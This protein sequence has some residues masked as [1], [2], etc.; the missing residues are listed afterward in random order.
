MKS[1]QLA[2]EKS[3]Y[4]LQHKDNPVHWYAWGEAAFADAER[5]QK[6]IFLSIGYSTCYWC[7][8][9]E[10]DSFE[11]EEVATVLNEHFI[12]IKVDREE[13][14]DVDEI[15]MDAVIALTGHGGWPMS[16]ID[17][18][19]K[20][21]LWRHIFPPR[22]IYCAIAATIRC[23]ENQRA[24]VLQT[25]KNI[26]EHLREPQGNRGQT[27]DSHSAIGLDAHIFDQCIA[28]FENALMTGRA[29]LVAR[30]NFRRAWALDCC[31]GCIAAL[32]MQE[33]WRWQNSRCKKWPVAGFLTNW[34]A[35]SIA[36]PRMKN[37]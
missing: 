35:D 8:V 28:T 29:A 20:A 17:A 11:L 31:S 2:H 27:S 23:L 9:M 15:Y 33:H 6:P 3:P 37:G 32:E 34:A 4:L 21:F 24:E 16:D 26:L 36:I 18:R 30:R 14:P 22:K 7:H 5:E 13:R 10:K 25:G 1:N 19:S 12:C